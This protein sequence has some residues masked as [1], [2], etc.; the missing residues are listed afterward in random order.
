VV[1][2]SLAG[3]GYAPALLV[4]ALRDAK[5]TGQNFYFVQA[6]SASKAIYERIGFKPA[7]E[8]TEYRLA[9]H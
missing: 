7:G 2:S 9:S 4:A 5:R 6:D 3:K 1:D 8:F